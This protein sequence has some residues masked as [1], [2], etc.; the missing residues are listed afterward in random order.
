MP[1]IKKPR[2]V[3]S[4]EE[5]STIGGNSY[6]IVQEKASGEPGKNK[7]GAHSSDKFAFRIIHPCPSRSGRVDGIS[8]LNY[9][10]AT[11]DDR[12]SIM[13][14]WLTVKGET[15]EWIL[16]PPPE[17]ATG[18]FKWSEFVT[19]LITVAQ[20]AAA[21][22]EDDNM[23]DSGESVNTN[24]TLVS[25]AHGSAL[26]LKRGTSMRMNSA[27]S[28]VAAASS[29]SRSV[30]AAS[31]S[32][33]DD[34]LQYKPHEIYFG[35]ILA[36]LY[37][38]GSEI[39]GTVRWHDNHRTILYVYASLMLFTRMYY[40][41][42]VLVIAIG[43]VLRV[44]SQSLDLEVGESD[45]GAL[46]RRTMEPIA[47]ALVQLGLIEKASSEDSTDHT[48]PDVCHGKGAIGVVRLWH[49]ALGMGML[50]YAG[51][52]VTS[53]MW[54][55]FFVVYVALIV[56][57]FVAKYV[58][59]HAATLDIVTMLQAPDE[60]VDDLD[61]PRAG[62]DATA[63]PQEPTATGGPSNPLHQT[64]L[65]AL[66]LKNSQ[67]W[68]LVTE[69]NDV[70]MH[71]MPVPWCGKKALHIKTTFKASFEDAVRFLY[72]KPGTPREE[73]SAFKF[74]TLLKDVEL[75]REVDDTK[76]VGYTRVMHT[77]F[78][79][80]VVGIT[81]RDIAALQT[82]CYLT[83]AQATQYGFPEGSRVFTQCGM[84]VTK[85]VPA[86]KGYVRGTLHVYGLFINTRPNSDNLDLTI[87]LSMDP[88]GWVPSKAVDASSIEQMNKAA[89][90]RKNILELAPSD[91]TY[92][93][94]DLNKNG[95]IPGAV[96]GE[97]GQQEE[98]S[99]SPSVSPRRSATNA[100]VPTVH[101]AV[102]KCL[103]LLRSNKWALNQ[104]KNGVRFLDQVVPWCGKKACLF[105]STVEAD[106]DTAVDYLDQPPGTPEKEMHLFE[107][108]T[109]LESFRFVKV[110]DEDTTIVYTSY[111]S[112]V[113]GVAP[114]DMVATAHQAW[115][116]QDQIKEYGFPDNS[117]VWLQASIDANDAAPQV[118][119]KTR[120]R[121][122]AYSLILCA[123]PATPGTLEVSIVM[124]IDPCGW[125]PNKAVDASNAEQ[126]EKI[127]LLKKGFLKHSP[128]ADAVAARRKKCENKKNAQTNVVGEEPKKETEEVVVTPTPP[129]TVAAER[130]PENVAKV[131]QLYRSQGWTVNREKNGVKFYDKSVP[132][133]GKKACL[134]TSTCKTTI[135]AVKD[136]MMEPMDMP[137]KERNAFKY[138][139][140]LDHY[141][142]F[143]QIDA[144]TRLL[145]TKYIA[146]I[147]GVTAR[148]VVVT[149]VEHTLTPEQCVE[150][151]F[152][153]N[154]QVFVIAN[155]DAGQELPQ[156]K[157][158]VRATVHAFG[159][160]CVEYKD[161]THSDLIMV[162]S[163]DPSG[164]VPTKAV[165]GANIE[166]I[167]KMLRIQKFVEKK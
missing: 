14:D 59:E 36:T 54:L 50:S 83:P 133:C 150:H 149:S 56:G 18:K 40:G 159:L 22:D 112:P 75:V 55:L 100:S 103:T 131:F 152:G 117:R 34:L 90:M 105:T 109:L 164:W 111:K 43:V 46:Y 21:A 79:S 44:H 115:L 113:F 125:I 8:T 93:M 146:P 5:W 135:A 88:N 37:P 134:Y 26:N 3:K 64:V 89:L 101:P 67:N 108:D 2:R 74:D 53:M 12:D 106:L 142:I 62:N 82:D 24:T 127:K 45:A 49:L 87:V 85:E 122:F 28:A 30:G 77:Y 38:L 71:D 155:T 73:I 15:S 29:P 9:V 10:L 167:E 48:L 104:E 137:E 57:G 84:D 66:Q 6:F 17:L 141:T 20:A 116:S 143:K 157:G 95:M 4:R 32:G 140:L 120:G 61:S 92:T 148:D 132:W 128:N 13:S 166:Q 11:A 102:T 7:F 119:G 114:R 99:S 39:V 124:S 1:F 41:P 86:A 31:Q 130:L 25:A 107:F 80:P 97:A 163:M 154:A 47:L 162:L 58:P 156:E 91:D 165:D 136:F 81:P 35:R 72:N 110:I 160:I 96:E 65:R 23:S 138:D 70:T 33:D 52:P 51:I 144:Q 129:P 126:L 145:H 158:Y 19:K 68:K 123:N 27:P 16:T 151:G 94:P 153:A 76:C 139:A 121:V 42:E 98:A 69:K 161:S 60:S 118:S 78:T 63:S 147:F